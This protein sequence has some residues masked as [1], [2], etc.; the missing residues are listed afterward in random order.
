MNT[1][2]AL[3]V[4]L[5]QVMTENH[6][7]VNQQKN[8]IAKSFHRASFTHLVYIIRQYSIFPRELVAFTKI[9]SKKAF[10]AGW[11]DVAWELRENIA[12]ELG[13]STNG[14]SHYDLLAEGLEEGL[15]LPIKTTKPSRA[16]WR[17]LDSLQIIS[18]QSASH[19]LGAMYAIEAT[20]IAELTIV[21]QLI[22]HL[23]KGKM[24]HQLRY[25]FEMHLNEWEPEHEEDLRK[26]LEQYI[27][28]TEFHQFKAG[29]CAVMTAMDLWWTEL[30]EEVNLPAAAVQMVAV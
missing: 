30:A 18:R 13:S 2:D 19:V 8:P 4:H 24:P 9:A 28:Q 15:Q 26:T 14:I 7:A 5:N 27:D 23:L 12:E 29:F 1:F 22:D 17:L 20:S 10:E 16:T 11:L 21:M 25:F 3:S 6:I